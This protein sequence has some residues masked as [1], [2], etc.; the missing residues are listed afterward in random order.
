MKTYTCHKRVTAMQIAAITTHVDDDTFVLHET[1]PNADGTTPGDWVLVSGD[2][3]RRHKPSK[4]GY[5][6]RYPDGYESY[7]PAAAF[8]S[9][10]I[11]VQS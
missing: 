4:L 2:W 5:Y 6:V 9:G 11:E 10:Y 1:V 8:E 3:M 7:S